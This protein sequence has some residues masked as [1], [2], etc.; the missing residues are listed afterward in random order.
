MDG[1]AAA[2]IIGAQ[3]DALRPDLLGADAAKKKAASQ[4]IKKLEVAL[5]RI[6]VAEADAVGPEIDKLVKALEKIRTAQQL[7]AVSALGRTIKRLRRARGTE[8]GNG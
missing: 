2:I 7:D 5:D 6:T 1:N 3:I 8:V 4:A